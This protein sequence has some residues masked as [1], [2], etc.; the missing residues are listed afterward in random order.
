[1]SIHETFMRRALEIARRGEG[2]VEPNPRVGAVLVRSGRIVG[3]GWHD[4]F[5]GP[6]AEVNALHAA[7]AGRRAKRAGPPPLRGA[8]LYVTLEPCAHFGKTPPCAP[9]VVEAGIRRVV[10]ATRDPNPI[11][12]GRGIAHLRRSGVEVVEGVLQAEA[13][14]LNAP[15]FALHRRGRP[16]VIAKWAMSADGRI[17]TRRGESMWITGPEARTF[18]R[19]IRARCQAVVVGIDTALRDDP[20]L[21]PGLPAP[22]SPYPRPYARVV[23]DSRARLP[24]RSKLVRTAS[25]VPVVVAVSARAPRARCR[26]LERAG[27]EVLRA[28]GSRTDVKKV[29]EAFGRRGFTHVMVE[30]GGAVLGS[31]FDAHLAD[32]VYVF[33]A[34]RVIGGREAPSPVAGSGPAALADGPV[35]E[36]TEWKTVGPDLLLHGYCPAQG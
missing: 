4:V 33:V 11:T 31:V 6:H 20:E 22:P 35:L 7:G 36:R 28:G 32:E 21:L 25:A 17:A 23:L 26:A 15:F 27:C 18:A 5:G 13:V 29:L 19:R 8:T 14:A 16:W 9:A 10:V 30:G 12:G 24:L 3:E 1:M 2:R 34:P